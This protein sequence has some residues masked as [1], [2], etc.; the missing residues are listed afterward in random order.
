MQP[1]R[2]IR[3][4]IAERFINSLLIPF[5]ILLMYS[6][7]SFF[8]SYSLCSVDYLSSLIGEYRI[9]CRNRLEVFHLLSLAYLQ[10]KSRTFLSSMNPSK[11]SLICTGPQPDGQPV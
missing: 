7:L 6:F 4:S 11:W 1:N 5:V 8:V 9:L 2:S 10:L 3:Q